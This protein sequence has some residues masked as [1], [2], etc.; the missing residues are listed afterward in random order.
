MAP[1]PPKDE[2]GALETL[3]RPGDLVLDLEHDEEDVVREI[4]KGQIHAHSHARAD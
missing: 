3:N 4:V 2:F 1:F